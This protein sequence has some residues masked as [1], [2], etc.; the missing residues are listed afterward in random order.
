MPSC[1]ESLQARAAK[2]THEIHT[3]FIME[4]NKSRRTH[5]V[6]S[7]STDAAAA[8]GIWDKRGEVLRGEFLHGLLSKW[9]PGQAEKGRHGRMSALL[10][11]RGCQQA[12]STV[13]PAL[14]PSVSVPTACTDMSIPSHYA[15]LSSESFS[16]L[17][18]LH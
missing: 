4:Y 15:I 14:P 12:T 9:N 10:K 16:I 18:S 6:F 8:G 13:T 3:V 5:T 1:Q 7:D 2:Q 11:G 17:S